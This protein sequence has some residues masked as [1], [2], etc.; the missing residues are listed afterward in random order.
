[1]INDPE[2]FKKL[3]GNSDSHSWIDQKNRQNAE[4]RACK[5]RIDKITLFKINKM[6]TKK[7]RTVSL[8]TMI[9]NHIGKE[10][11]PPREIFEQELKIELLG[12]LIKEARLH[13]NLTQEQ[14]GKLVGVQKAQISKLENN[15]TNARIDTVLRVFN[16]LNA[17]VR[18]KVEMPKRRKPAMPQ[19]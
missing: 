15:F 17:K 3:T 13:Q 11:T 14:L 19:V 16:A 10:G 4:N 7:P 6:S 12:L 1:M 2:L 5:S 8:E 9:D 18:F